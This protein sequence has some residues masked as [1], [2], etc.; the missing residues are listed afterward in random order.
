MAFAVEDFDSKR[1]DRPGF[2]CG[3]ETPNRYLKSLATQHR[4]KGI[5]ATF[6]LIDS[7][8]ITRILGFYSLSVTALSF[9]K[10]AD[11]G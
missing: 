6:V 11:A 7:D 5:V 8:Q 3:N 1:H 4:A 10:L 2:D 9:E